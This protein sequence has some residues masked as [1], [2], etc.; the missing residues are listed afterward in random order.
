MTS[1]S[2]A[3]PNSAIRLGNLPVVLPSWSDPRLKLSLVIISLQVLG[4]TVLGFKLSIAQILVTVGACAAV[5]MTLTLRRQRVLVWPASALLTGNSVAFILRASGTR[6]GDWWTLHGIQYF[7]LAALLALMSKYLIRPNGRHLFNPSNV[8]LVWTLLIIGPLHVF[9]Q[10][11]YWGPIGAPVV[12]ALAVIVL[13]AIWILRSVKMFAMAVSFWATLAG[14]VAIF[15][16]S[17]RSFVAVWHSGPVGGA[18]YWV[19][20]CLSPE[21]LIFVFFMM[22]DPRTAARTRVGRIVYG[23]ATAV[24]AAAVLVWQPTEFG[25]KLAV[26]SSLT[27]VCALVPSIDGFARRRATSPSGEPDGEPARARRVTRGWRNPALVA[28]AL[29]A[30]AAP[31]DTLALTANKQLGYIE[32][33]LTGSRN[34]Q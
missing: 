25:V 20:I 16:L 2:A 19:D 33:G 21:L 23:A 32:R 9:P 5:D 34:P 29:I 14:L 1:S 22:S 11:L 28:A 31:V 30:L 13:G 6:H 7:L 8:G 17:G 26:L 18:P 15:A 24:V 3:A 10:Y 4:Q 27:L 12:G